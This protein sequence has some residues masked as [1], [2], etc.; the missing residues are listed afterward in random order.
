MTPEQDEHEEPAKRRAVRRHHQKRLKNK[1]K[2]LA[3]QEGVR[4]DYSHDMAT[5]Y[6]KNINHL[7]SCS[8]EMCR[9]PRRSGW[10]RAKGITRKEC[11]AEHD[12]IDQA[13]T[14]GE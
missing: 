7:K 5:Y 6:L 4:W 10:R 2:R 9:N 8:C 3:K 13:N 11:Q 1:A 12:L 14:L